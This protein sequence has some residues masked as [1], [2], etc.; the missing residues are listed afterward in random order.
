MQVMTKGFHQGGHQAAAICRDF[1]TVEETNACAANNL[2]KNKH[3]A[4]PVSKCLNQK[5][6]RGHTAVRQL[7]GNVVLRLRH[8]TSRLWLDYQPGPAFYKKLLDILKTGNAS[9]TN[10]TG[11]WNL[12]LGKI[13]NTEMGNSLRAALIE[14]RMDYQEKS[15]N[16]NRGNRT[17]RPNGPNDHEET[18]R[19]NATLKAI[20]ERHGPEGT[21]PG[22]YFW[23]RLTQ[24]AVKPETGSRCSDG[25]TA[26]PGVFPVLISFE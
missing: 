5:E 13:N 16:S 10:Q 17:T 22:L 26:F 1:V 20:M 6:A 4:S 18:I 11:R 21:H 2:A 24:D 8:L 7:D 15:K 12:L 3:S 25:A 9:S 14:M 23:I 19:N